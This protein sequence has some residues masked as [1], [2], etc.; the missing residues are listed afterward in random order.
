[1]EVCCFRRTLLV[2]VLSYSSCVSTQVSWYRCSHVSSYGIEV[3]TT[4]RIAICWC[5]AVIAEYGSK[6]TAGMKA[7]SHVAI[8]GALNRMCDDVIHVSD[9]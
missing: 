5:R 2:A 7:V 9:N 8:Q 1:M 4:V 6:E 3:L